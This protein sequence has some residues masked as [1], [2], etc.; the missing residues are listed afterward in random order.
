MLQCATPTGTRSDRY[1]IID[2]IPPTINTYHP[3]RGPGCSFVQGMFIAGRRHKGDE[4][5][6][7]DKGHD[8]LTCITLSSPKYVT[9]PIS[10]I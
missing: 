4:L 5:I 7:R 8:I 3:V 10:S 9:F 1:P 2:T 6:E